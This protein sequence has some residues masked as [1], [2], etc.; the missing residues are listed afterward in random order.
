MDGECQDWFCILQK[1]FLIGD[2]ESLF[3]KHAIIIIFI[4]FYLGAFPNWVVEN[5]LQVTLT[6]K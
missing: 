1:M 2:L 6:T 5:I 3:K 4:I